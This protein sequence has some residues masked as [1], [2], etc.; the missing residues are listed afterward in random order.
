MWELTPV[1][2]VQ[3]TPANPPCK[4]KYVYAK[5][6][7]FVCIYTR[8]YVQ[9]APCQT[10]YHDSNG[11]TIYYC[12]T[13]THTHTQKVWFVSLSLVHSLHGWL[14][15]FSHSSNNSAGDGTAPVTGPLAAR[16]LVTTT[17]VC[18]PCISSERGGMA[19]V[20]VL[21]YFVC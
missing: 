12:T 11:S 7:N 16:A 5:H 13:H 18:K 19:R 20:T 10:L 6:L 14:L 4:N 21:N 2:Y 9:E 1:W 17:V 8:I 3:Q 15:H